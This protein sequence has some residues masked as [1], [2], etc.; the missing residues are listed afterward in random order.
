VA[1]FFKK[2]HISVAIPGINFNGRE[3]W[4]KK[5]AV[6]GACSVSDVS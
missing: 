5:S 2:Y 1:L 4:K 6:E 3:Y